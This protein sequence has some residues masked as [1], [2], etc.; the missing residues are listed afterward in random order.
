MLS[1]PPSSKSITLFIFEG[2]SNKKKKDFDIIWNEGK[3]STEQ[4]M[5]RESIFLTEEKKKSDTNS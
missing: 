5:F 1:C 3:M 2:S 4:D